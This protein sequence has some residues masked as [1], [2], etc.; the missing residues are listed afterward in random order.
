ME[1]RSVYLL[2]IGN[3]HFHAQLL[4][5]QTEMEPKERMANM[6]QTGQKVVGSLFQIFDWISLHTARFLLNQDRGFRVKDWRSGSGI[7]DRI[8]LTICKNV[9]TKFPKTNLKRPQNERKWSE[10][11]LWFTFVYKIGTFLW[12]QCFCLCV[13]HLQIVR[14]RSESVPGELF[15]VII[16]FWET[17]HLPLPQANTTTY[18]LLRAKVWLRGGVGEQF[19]TDV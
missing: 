5:K 6:A 11:G 2:L 7:E 14:L 4:P 10:N 8:L 1:V 19:P 15:L 13:F 16:R 12:A 17:A 18:F 3:R 9:L